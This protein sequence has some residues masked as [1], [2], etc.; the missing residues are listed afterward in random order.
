MAQEIDKKKKKLHCSSHSVAASN[1]PFQLCHV[2]YPLMKKPA[3]FGGIQLMNLALWE[4]AT[5]Q[6]DKALF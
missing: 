5:M 6:V 4:Q 3:N 1:P 2:G